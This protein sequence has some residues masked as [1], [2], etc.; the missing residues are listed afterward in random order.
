M[1]EKR[2][3]G[4]VWPLDTS[5]LE[6]FVKEKFGPSRAM[7]PLSM[8]NRQGRPM[9]AMALSKTIRPPFTTSASKPPPRPSSV[10]NPFWTK[11]WAFPWRIQSLYG[12]SP[13]TQST[14]RS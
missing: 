5:M 6:A 11:V 3:L 14:P 7:P 9:A 13:K 8:H 2:G 1:N 12:P 10:I 4:A